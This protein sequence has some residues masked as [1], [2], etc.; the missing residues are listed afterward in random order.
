MTYS[1]TREVSDRLRTHRNGRQSKMYDYIVGE[2]EGDIGG[3][4][5]KR[6]S[7]LRGL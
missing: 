6:S 1:R 5:N 3:L 7:K 2:R 4:A